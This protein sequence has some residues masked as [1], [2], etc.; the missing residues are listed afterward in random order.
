M[1]KEIQECFG[2]WDDFV[3]SYLE[4]YEDATGD[5]SGERA[6]LYETLRPASG[7]HTL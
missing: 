1:A 5:S 4:G 6:E 2:S 7:I 3:D